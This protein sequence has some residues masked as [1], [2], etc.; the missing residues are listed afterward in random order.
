MRAIGRFRGL[1]LATLLGVTLS[2]AAGAVAQATPLGAPV[3]PAVAADG[4]VDDFVFSE[5]HADYVLSRD[6]AG[7]ARL[8]TTERFVARFP[9]RDQNRGIVRAIPLD[10]DGVNLETRLLSVTDEG[11][12]E[13]TVE[14]WEDDGF[15]MVATGDDRYLRGEHTFV[16]SYAQQHTARAFADTGADEFYWDT[17]GIAW[18]QPF[19]RATAEIR[20]S[21]E[22]VEARTGEQA[23]YRGGQGATD[24]CTITAD[25]TSPE[26]LRADS[27]GPL[28]PEETM[29]VAIGFAPGTFVIPEAPARSWWATWL[30]GALAALSAAAIAVTATVRARVWGHDPGRGVVVPQYG[31]PAGVSLLEAGL[32]I[33]RPGQSVPATIIDLAVRGA[34]RIQDLGTKA[35]KP[36]F[37]LQF[38]RADGLADP[39][40]DLL[41]ALYGEEPVPGQVLPMH[42]ANTKRASRVGEVA[43]ALPERLRT[44]G[45]TH[46]APGSFPIW[47]R[48]LPLA[49]GLLT[50]VGGIIV[51]VRG[52]ENVFAV[53]ALFV[54]TIVFAVGGFFAVRPTRR[55][56]AGAE[57]AEEIDGI[58]MYVELA[59]ADRYAVLQSVRS[60]ER[61]DVAD[62]R[63]LVRLTEQLLP[64]A[65]LWG[66]EKD[67]ARELGT[68]YAAAGT[69]PV[70]YPSSQPFT[71]AAF[72]ASLGTFGTQAN[73][74]IS[75]PGQGASGGSFS[76]GSSGGGFAGGGGG[77]GGGGGR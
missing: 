18:A 25:T 55:T 16:F 48:L 26:L 44:R 61:I 60:A 34:V 67:W 66:L 64:Y 30:P 72:A 38:V 52:G 6:D 58:K 27:D 41:R 33:E 3:R 74:A 57:L 50:T 39:E 65:V 10:Y 11:G 1:L 36:K 63:Q 42:Q 21:P 73:T 19:A 46:P 5:Y 53:V 13:V 12:A 2:F 8:L 24:R 70:W 68:A 32:L 56:R 20:L 29:T 31:P 59:E 37:A 43:K 22:L 75:A 23:C 4:D 28:G 49:V 14:T 76:G 71:G 45:W 47:L 54:G 7:S 40:R 15:L 17:N 51:L 77:G 69:G 62:T 35:S 9:D